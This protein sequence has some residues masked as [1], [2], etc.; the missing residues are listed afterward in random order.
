MINKQTLCISKLQATGKSRYSISGFY[1]L[2]CTPISFNLTGKLFT[3]QCMIRNVHC[4]I[5][6][7]YL[8]LYIGNTFW[9][10]SLLSCNI[11]CTN[12]S[13]CVIWCFKI[14]S[15]KTEHSE[16]LYLIE[17]GSR[18]G[19]L[20]DFFFSFSYPA[21]LCVSLTELSYFHRSELGPLRWLHDIL[22]APELQNRST[23]KRACWG[24]FGVTHMAPSVTTS[25]A[26]NP[27]YFLV[28]LWDLYL[29]FPNK[30]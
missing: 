30:Q 2:Y 13:T 10:F 14:K 18:E 25:K 22:T 27:I 16:F 5:M 1:C 20:G 17:M 26:Q 7:R 12:W 9:I 15:D 4:W 8:L 19:V 11:I 29:P 3:P 28:R 24:F 23:E 6:M 21:D